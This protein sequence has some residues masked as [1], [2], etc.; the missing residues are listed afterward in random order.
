MGRV[1]DL[2]QLS[3]EELLGLVGSKIADARKAMDRWRVVRQEEW[4]FYDFHMELS[5]L[6]SLIKTLCTWGIE[7]EAM[8]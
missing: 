4:K 3:G 6:E 2:F 1:V 5:K 7:L 8:R